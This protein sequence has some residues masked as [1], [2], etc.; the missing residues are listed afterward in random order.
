MIT[1][2]TS[3]ITVGAFTTTNTNNAI[4]IKV[5]LFMDGQS[6]I[7]VLV[8]MSQGGSYP[9]IQYSQTSFNATAAYTVEVQVSSATNNP[10]A[11]NNDV[12]GELK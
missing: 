10:I 7:N 6:F 2:G 1:N 8:E 11:F 4:V 3:P 12:L 9:F 5:R